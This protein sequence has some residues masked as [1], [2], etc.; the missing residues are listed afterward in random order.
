MSKTCTT[1]RATEY[2]KANYII[3]LTGERNIKSLHVY[4][5]NK[6]HSC[7]SIGEFLAL[8]KHLTVRDY[9]LVP[10]PNYKCDDD[11]LVVKM[12]YDLEKHSKEECPRRWH[13]Y[14]HCFE[15]A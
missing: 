12:M 11:E 15:F 9:A 7:E 3:L 10:C 8:S 14:S 4:C 6:V 1:Q 13:Q 5:D 2:D